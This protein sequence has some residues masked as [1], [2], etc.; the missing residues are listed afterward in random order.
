[1]DEDTKFVPLTVRRNP[2]LPADGLAGCREEIAG[3]GLVAA[4]V[5]VSAFEVPLRARDLSR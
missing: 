2:A 5:N 3:I 1:M 4:I